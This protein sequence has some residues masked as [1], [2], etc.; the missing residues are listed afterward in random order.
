MNRKGFTWFVLLMFT[1]IFLTIM[2][3]YMYTLQEAFQIQRMATV[4]KEDL[5]LSALH[6]AHYDISKGRYKGGAGYSS[7][8]Y[9]QGWQEVT[10]GKRYTCVYNIPVKISSTVTGGGC[11]GLKLDGD[12]CF[13]L[14]SSAVEEFE[15]VKVEYKESGGN[16]IIEI[17]I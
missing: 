6:L 9:A 4:M 2:A 8:Y 12:N 14:S 16:W 1:L 11:A 10:P 15:Q 5:L 17:Q 7:L 3:T 13:V